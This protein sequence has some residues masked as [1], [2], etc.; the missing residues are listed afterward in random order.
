MAEREYDVVLLSDLRYPGGNSAS[1]AEEVKAQAAAG[2]TTA[3]MHVP[4]PHALS[5]R[6]FN[7]KLAHCL[8]AGLA[9]LV[10]DDARVRARALVIRQPRVFDG[11]PAVSPRIDAQATV[12]VANQ[13]PHDGLRPSA[14]PYY[15]VRTVRDR[16]AALFGQVRWAPIARPVRTALERCGVELDLLEHD[17]VNIVD[18]AEWDAGTT[19]FVADRPV[20]GRHSRDHASKWPVD[21]ADILGAYPDDPGVRVEVL[22]GAGPAVRALGRLPA[23]WTVHP[24]GAMTPQR[25][26]RRIDFFV[27]HHHPGWIEAFGRTI[28]EAMASG[29]P[30]LLPPHFE[31]VFGD[32]ARYGPPSDTRAIVEALYAD[33]AAYAAVAAGGRDFVASRFGP[34]VHAE[35]LRA[36]IGAP[37]GTPAAAPRAPS[38]RVLLVAAGAGESA[39]DGRRGRGAARGGRAGAAVLRAGSAGGRACGNAGRD[40]AR[41]RGARSAHRRRRAPSRR[42]GGDRRRRGGE[43]R[44]SRVDRRE[45]R[46]AGGPMSDELAA[47]RDALRAERARSRTLERELRSLRTSASFRLGHSLVIVTRAVGGVRPGRGFLRRLL[48]VVRGSGGEQDRPAGGG[49]VMFVAWGADPD[50]LERLVS[51]VERLRAV[52]VDLEPV[53]LLDATEIDPILRTG[54]RVE[55]VTGL[56]EWRRHRPAHTWGRY[57]VDRVAEAMAEHRP[58]AVVVVES[59]TAPGAIEQGVLDAVILPSLGGSEDNLLVP[60]GSG[61][62]R[63]LVLELLEQELARGDRP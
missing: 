1:L 42:R 18:P 15:D 59:G 28:I 27:Y 16:A 38:R 34:G 2:Y 54:H 35:R 13:P 45:R 17:W 55:H 31:A 62:P 47:V 52:L 39:E 57:V 7:R 33:P 61:T 40:A 37:S 22:G 10:P 20:I 12:L 36:L 63:T 24:F 32:A 56:D 50:R 51:R 30:A 29:R 44:G 11:E 43:D 49:T 46:R 53:F 9:D 60:G 8:H 21:A 3:L 19:G 26:L 5:L 41:G 23:N 4:A 58:R 48:T 14:R 6:C 25:F